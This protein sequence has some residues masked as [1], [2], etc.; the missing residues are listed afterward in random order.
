MASSPPTTREPRGT[1]DA[2]FAAKGLRGSKAAAR[3]HDD[4]EAMVLLDFVADRGLSLPRERNSDRALWRKLR[5]AAGA[6]GVGRVFPRLSRNP[7]A[8]DHLPFLARGIPAID[9]IDFTFECFH[10]PCDDMSAV[11]ERSVDAT[12]EAVLRLLA[13]L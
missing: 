8:D 1:P 2:E 10:Q 4:A 13:S 7:V 9:L 6:V 3:R 12:G 11:S 5:R